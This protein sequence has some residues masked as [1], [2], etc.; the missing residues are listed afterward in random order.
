[1]EALELGIIRIYEDEKF[2]FIYP[3]VKVDG[4]WKNTN[5]SDESAEI[6]DFCN[7]NWNDSITSNY[8]LHIDDNLVTG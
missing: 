7:E 8:Q 5:L 2:R 6:Q 1:M 3:A 4:V